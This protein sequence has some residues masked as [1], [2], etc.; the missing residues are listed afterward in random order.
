MS[1]TACGFLL[2][3]EGVGRLVQIARAVVE[4]VKQDEHRLCEVDAIDGAPV[5]EDIAAESRL[6]RLIRV[7][8]AKL[9][10]EI[11]LRRDER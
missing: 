11:P 7:V 2:Q 5:L 6:A 9:A 8:V 3:A 1:D 4:R 10:V